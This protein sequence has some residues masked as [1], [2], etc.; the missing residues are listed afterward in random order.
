[1]MLLFHSDAPCLGLQSTQS[2]SPQPLLPR[3]ITG[4]LALGGRARASAQRV[5]RRAQQRAVRRARRQRR[6]LQDQPP[7]PSLCL[8]P[9]PSNAPHA[10]LRIQNL[11]LS[12]PSSRLRPRVGW[13]GRSRDDDR[14]ACEPWTVN[15]VR[16]RLVAPYSRRQGDPLRR[17]HI[18]TERGRQHIS[19]YNQTLAFRRSSSLRARAPRSLDQPNTATQH[20]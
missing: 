18:N 19:I 3:T 14:L 15:L 1:M 11:M 6:P 7:P 2:P 10:S 5:P 16:H 4:P 12:H 8:F 13:L 20:N 9:P 17:V